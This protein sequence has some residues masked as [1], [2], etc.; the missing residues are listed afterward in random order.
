M[1][2]APTTLATAQ[3]VPTVGRRS[4]RGNGGSY[5]TPPSMRKVDAISAVPMGSRAPVMAVK[6][7]G[8]S[9]DGSDAESAP[10][11]SWATA[12]PSSRRE[13]RSRKVSRF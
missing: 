11:P 9:P 13:K 1:A 3:P 5:V 2:P 7:V 12:Q 4:R 10:V 8:S 6:V